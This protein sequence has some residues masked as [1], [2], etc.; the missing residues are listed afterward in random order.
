M[1]QEQFDLLLYLMADHQLRNTKD[2]LL[3][4]QRVERHRPDGDPAGYE[5]ELAAIDSELR[6]RREEADAP[7]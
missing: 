7:F 5:S 1:D 4:A 6:R 3:A 2:D